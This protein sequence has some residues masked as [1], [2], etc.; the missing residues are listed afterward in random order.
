MFLGVNIL[1][2]YVTIRKKTPEDVIFD[3]DV[4]GTRFHLRSNY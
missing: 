2:F 1:Y 3:R 4:L